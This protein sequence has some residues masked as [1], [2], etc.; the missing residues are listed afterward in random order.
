MTA[1]VER[2]PEAPERNG[3]APR[4]NGAPTYPYPE[5]APPPAAPVR[6]VPWPDQAREDNPAVITSTVA[7]IFAAFGLIAVLALGLL[8][9]SRGGIG[10]GASGTSGAS[11]AT[12]ASTLDVTASEFKF[13]PAPLTIAAPGKLTVNLANT[14][15]VEHDLH[16]EGIKGL[17]H[18]K[19]GGAGTGTFD[20]P[21]AGSYEVFCTI[22]GHKEAG[23]KTTLTVGGAVPG[24]AA[25]PAAG[26][27]ALTAAKLAPAIAGAKPLPQPAVAPPVNRTTPALVKFEIETREVVGQ[28]ADGTTYTYW[29][30]NGT[31]PGPMLRVRQ[32]DDVELTI[33]NAP[34]SKVIHSIDL[35]AVTG[36]GG[37]A[38]VT[39]VP[40]SGTATFRFKALNPGVYVYHCATPMVAHHIASGMYGLIVVE[41]EAGYT[42]VDREFYL[43]QGDFYLSGDRGQ[44]GHHEIGMDD[45]MAENPDYVVFNGSVGALTGDNA[46]KA[47]VGETI[48][49]F[50]GVG[51]PN[52][53]S[54]FHVIG[55]IFDRVHPEG[56]TQALTN[57]QTTLV[58]TG[59]AIIAEF[60]VEV[61]GNYII[62]DHSLTRLE[63]GGA[64]I[65]TVSGPE[66][67]AIFQPITH[68]T[69]GAGG[70]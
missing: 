25:L 35:H 26:S 60:K 24:A 54:S 61:P 59:G 67:P 11:V 69:G 7:G 52:L 63:K 56:A 57:V 31:V 9:G 51:G 66:N 15:A 5:P 58:P 18:A 32:G 38:T 10:R 40:A 28:M 14:G 70:H 20:I 39:Q 55:E 62:V 17:A 42:K 29:T 30:F 8:L 48:R 16:I 6:D 47:N 13:A 46:L 41:P 34:D 33:K 21:K 19:A 45:M 27:T 2:P 65:L 37:G 53:T 68:G 43:M 50:F 36:P 4:R 12:A 22:P 23:M 64:A 49:L 3:H 44:P 1:T